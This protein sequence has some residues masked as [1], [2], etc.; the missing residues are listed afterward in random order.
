MSKPD[1][2]REACSHVLSQVYEFHDQAITEDEATEIRQHLLA[3][4]PCLD[5]YDV[6][7]A[8]R[9]LIRRCFE[10]EHAPDELRLKI[11]T[12]YS[13]TVVVKDSD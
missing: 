7:Q 6:E 9:V 13:H 3:C 10:A 4:E 2:S 12:S 11:R 5:Q 1:V 8:M